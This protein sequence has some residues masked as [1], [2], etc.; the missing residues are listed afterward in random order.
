[1][2]IRDSLTIAP[3]FLDELNK[4]KGELIKKL[5]EDTQS[6]TSID[7]KFDE[8]D[9]RLNMLEDQMASEKL[10][11]GITGFSKAIEELEELLIK[12]LSEI[13]NQKLIS[14]T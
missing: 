14:A 2:C 7:Y 5:D 8:K 11:E 3:K 10:S 6:K 9:F 12:R 4:E 13:N 1:M